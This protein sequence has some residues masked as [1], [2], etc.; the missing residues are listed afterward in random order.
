MPDYFAAY[1]PYA[2]HIVS[3]RGAFPGDRVWLSGGA[4]FDHLNPAATDP[5]AARARLGLPLDRRIILITTQNY[6][7][8]P[9]AA[10]AVF[11]AALNQPDWFVCLKT[12]PIDVPIDVYREVAERVG[13][14]AVAFFESQFEDLLASCDVLASASSTTVLEAILL[15]KRTVC[16]NFSDEEDWFPYVEDGGSLPGG[17]DDEVRASLGRC[18]DPSAQDELQAARRRFLD[19][20]IPLAADGHAAETLAQ[21]IAERSGLPRSP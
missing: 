18:F 21:Q 6:P 11:R 2:R 4:R 10:E 9:R 13:L 5:S 16:L 1:G 12:H 17:S 7:W 8:F 19:R 15:G 14:K 3:E 20:H